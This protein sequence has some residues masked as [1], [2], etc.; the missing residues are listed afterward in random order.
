MENKKSKLSKGFK[1]GI[2]L[3]VIFLAGFLLSFIII[4]SS[5]NFPVTYNPAIEQTVSADGRYVAGSAEYYEVQI[6][7]A[8]NWQLGKGKVWR[9]IG[10]VVLVALGIYII[11]AA[12]DV[13][14][15][16]RASV[17]YPLYVLLVIAAACIFASHSASLGSNKINLPKEKYLEVKDSRDKLTE[18]FTSREFVR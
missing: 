7:P 1:A 9:W 17:N 8:L 18:L 4:K 2:A 15:L 13:I 5:K 6:S 16:P 14:I 11:L 12:T 3:Y 10:L